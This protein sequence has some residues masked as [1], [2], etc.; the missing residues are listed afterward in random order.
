MLKAHLYIKVKPHPCLSFLPRLAQFFMQ[1]FSY[2]CPHIPRS[3]PLFLPP[4]LPPPTNW[5]S[6]LDPIF[7]TPAPSHWGVP[8]PQQPSLSRIYEIYQLGYI[9]IYA[10]GSQPGW[11]TLSSCHPR[12][13]CPSR[14]NKYLCKSLS[15]LSHLSVLK[16]KEKGKNPRLFSCTHRSHKT[17][18]QNHHIWPFSVIICLGS[19]GFSWERGLSLLF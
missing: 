10:V 1:I 19:F 4:P 8:P 11:G 3:I 17:V 2:Q 12:A 18:L 14:T 6:G 9:G 5:T 16:Q 15:F 7:F 13:G